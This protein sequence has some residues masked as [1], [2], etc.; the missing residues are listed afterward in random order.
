MPCTTRGPQSSLFRT[1]YLRFAAD[2]NGTVN[3]FVRD[4]QNDP[5]SQFTVLESIE[6]LCAALDCARVGGATGP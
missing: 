6:A 4:S 1:E 2:T 3:I 5:P